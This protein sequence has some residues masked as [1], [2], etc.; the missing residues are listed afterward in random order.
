MIVWHY[1]TAPNFFKIVESR[2]LLPTDSFIEEGEKPILWFSSDQYWELTANKGVSE[3][4]CSRVLTMEE[5]CERG[6]GLAR[7]GLAVDKNKKILFPFNQLCKKAKMRPEIKEGL[8][9]AGKKQGSSFK[10]W[11]GTLIPVD[12]DE[13]EYIEVIEEETMKWKRVWQ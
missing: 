10:K 6:G 5:T 12:I 8:K 9:L 1:T 13:C 4:G 3:N 2:L 7:F 11:Y